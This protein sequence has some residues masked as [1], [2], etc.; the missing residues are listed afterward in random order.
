MFTK[1]KWYDS[2][3]PPPPTSSIASAKPW[4]CKCCCKSKREYGTNYICKTTMPF[5]LGLI[6]C[7]IEDSKACKTVTLFSHGREI[8][9]IEQSLHN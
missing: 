6:Y 9:L 5:D 4:I 8:T 3:N 2:G 1:M 7:L